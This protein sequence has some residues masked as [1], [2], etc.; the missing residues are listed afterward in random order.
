MYRITNIRKMSDSEFNRYYDLLGRLINV[1]YIDVGY[2]Y[3]QLKSIAFDKYEFR[4]FRYLD[5]L[6]NS[7]WNSDGSKVI[8]PFDDLPF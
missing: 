1:A 3:E 4:E 6:Y 5:A 2:T 7:H 8:V